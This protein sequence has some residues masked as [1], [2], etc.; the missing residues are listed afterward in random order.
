MRRIRQQD[1]RLDYSMNILPRDNYFDMSL[2]LMDDGL[3]HSLATI[4]SLAR[5]VNLSLS[6]PQDP[7][8]ERILKRCKFFALSWQNSSRPDQNPISVTFEDCCS[9]F[10]YLTYNLP[11]SF[12]AAIILVMESLPNLFSGECPFVPTHGHFSHR[13]ILTNPTTREITEIIDWAEVGI[14]PFGFA[15]YGLENLLGYLTLCGWVF[16]GTADYL[17]DGF[18]GIFC[19]L[20]G[21]VCPSSI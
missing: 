10:N 4:R 19:E 20:V 1:W 2:T 17:R 8:N 16:H 15:V 9:I 6:F 21:E 13:N 12:Q 11:S 3:D 14:L 5:F 7:I 18:W